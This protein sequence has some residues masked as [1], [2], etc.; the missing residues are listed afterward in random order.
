[1]L[2]TVVLLLLCALTALAGVPLILKLV[3]PNDVF[4]VRTERALEREDFW[5]E[6][7][8]FAGWALVAAAGLTALAV[9]FYSGT[10]LRPFLRQVLVY[11]L[12]VGLAFGT[13]FWYERQVTLHGVRW[14]PSKKSRSRRRSSRRVESVRQP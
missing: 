12:F 6:A 14:S 3:P 7:N 8:W 5:Y 13:S 10:V 4:G 9:L 11:A 2:A 1:M